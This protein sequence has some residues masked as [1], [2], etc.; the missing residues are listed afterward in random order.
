LLNQLIGH[1]WFRERP[2]DALAGVRLLGAPSG[3]PSFPSDHATAAFAVS[4]GIGLGL[5]RLGTILLAESALLCIA[6]VAMGLHYPGDVVAGFLIAAGSVAVCQRL[7][8]LLREP[9]LAGA[10]H[11][12]A[13]RL[14]VRLDERKGI[15]SRPAADRL[16]LLGLVVGMP[17]LIEA[18]ADPFRLQPEWAEAF[19][20][21]L[22]ALG[23]IAAVIVLEMGPLRLPQAERGS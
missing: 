14:A 19:V 2:Y 15:V 17:A 12:L 4:L 8:L 23:L 9:L 5:P 16:G 7:A 21:T 6:R 3:D 11:L 1:I 13:Q 22:V 10:R 20:L 18:T